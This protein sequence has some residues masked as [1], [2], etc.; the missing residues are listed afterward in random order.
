M[1]G[2]SFQSLQ[3]QKVRHPARCPGREK[4]EVIKTN[5]TAGLYIIQRSVVRSIAKVGS[6]L[7]TVQLNISISKTS[8]FILVFDVK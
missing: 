1:S 3:E 5:I 7:Y 8:H 4:C 6:V 2:Q